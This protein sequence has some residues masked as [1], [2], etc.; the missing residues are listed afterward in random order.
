MP[1]IVPVDDYLIVEVIPNNNVS[2]GGI[3]IPDKAVEESVTG[4]VVVLNQ[5][6]YWRDGKLRNDPLCNL[7]DT[8]V[9]AKNSGTKVVH[10]GD[11]RELLAIPE[12]CI[13]YRVVED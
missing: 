1:K 3:V 4:R 8:V 6:S 11:G 2:A 9:F 12:N 7:G 13:Y 5:H 10:C